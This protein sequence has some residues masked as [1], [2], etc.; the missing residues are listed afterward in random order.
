MTDNFKATGSLVGMTPEELSK[1]P[2]PPCQGCYGSGLS[3]TDEVCP[4]C[5]GKGSL[6]TA[7]SNGI[8]YTH[9]F[10]DEAVN[11]EEAGYKISVDD[12]E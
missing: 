3:I 1:L 12:E 11:F 4:I 5:S 7:R 10:I 8:S 2:I 9:I 6:E